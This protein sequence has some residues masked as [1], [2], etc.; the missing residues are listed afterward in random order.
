M[1]DFDSEF[2]A[3]KRTAIVAGVFMAL[4]NLAILSGIA[5]VVYKVLQHFQII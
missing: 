2:K 1:N 5:F 4:I 3:V